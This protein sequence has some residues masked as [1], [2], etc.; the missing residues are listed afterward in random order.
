MPI[1]K[2]IQSGN[3][4]SQNQNQ[5]CLADIGEGRTRGGP[6]VGDWGKAKGSEAIVR[7]QSSFTWMDDDN[8]PL[9]VARFCYTLVSDCLINSLS[10]GYFPFSPPSST[11]CSVAANVNS[12]G[13]LF[14]QITSMGCIA[15]WLP[16]GFYWAKTPKDQRVN[17]RLFIPLASSLQGS[18]G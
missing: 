4:R 8:L 5:A 14:K 11:F 1:W 2:G 6:E 17:G 15:L 16:V 12:P 9:K 18:T 3:T 13:K 7:K 10:A